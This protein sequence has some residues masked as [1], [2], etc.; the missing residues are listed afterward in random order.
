MR[1][2]VN[3]IA[4]ILPASWAGQLDHRTRHIRNFFPYGGPMNGQT[5][6]AEIVREL[7]EYCGV[8]RIIETGTFRGTTTEWFA[9]FDL[10]V[11]S[12]EVMPRF[13]AFSR[14]RLKDFPKVRI[15]I[16]NSVDG[17]KQI[18][19]DLS[20]VTL[21]YLDA[22]WYDYLP[23]RDEY[24]LIREKFPKAVIVIDDF[25]VPHDALYTYDD[26]GPDM[27]LTLDYMQPA[28]DKAPAI[29]FPAVPAKYETGQR[30]GCTVM[31]TNAELAAI[32][33]ARIPLL[34]KW[35]A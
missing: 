23:L 26:Y 34:R 33:A 5:A 16:S 10:P 7:I 8:E 1:K 21:F 3:A 32:I 6:R 31:T 4:P 27:A 28:F 20:K 35:E 25:K 29:F 13:A 30:R 24:L 14:K 9:G 17:L 18:T 2:L 19:D 12:F 22:H 11:L 15:E